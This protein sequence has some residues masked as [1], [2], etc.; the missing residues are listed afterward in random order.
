MPHPSPGETSLCAIIPRQHYP[1]LE[2]D[3]STGPEFH[4]SQMR[5]TVAMLMSV[6]MANLDR[7]QVVLSALQKPLEYEACDRQGTADAR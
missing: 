5:H 1:K 3:P 4:A 2:E 7:V 6:L